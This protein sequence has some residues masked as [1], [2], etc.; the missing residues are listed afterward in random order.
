MAVHRTAAGVL[1][2]VPR[3]GE[4]AGVTGPGG[5]GLVAGERRRRAL[6]RKVP[7]PAR[8]ARGR[9]W[10]G[11][12]RRPTGRAR[13]AAGPAGRAPPRRC[14]AGFGVAWAA[15]DRAAGR[16]PIRAS[17]GGPAPPCGICAMTRGARSRV[18]LPAGRG[19]PRLV[20]RSSWPWSAPPGPGQPRTATG[21]ASRAGGR[22]L[23]GEGLVAYSIPYGLQAAADPVMGVGRWPRVLP[24]NVAEV[25]SRHL[26]GQDPAGG[27][28]SPSSWWPGTVFGGLRPAAVRRDH[29]RHRDRGV[30][31]ARAAPDQQQA[32]P[33][34]GR[35]ARRAQAGIERTAARRAEAS[36]MDEMQTDGH[37]RP[38]AARGRRSRDAAGLPGLPAGHAGVEMPGPERRAAA[39]VAAADVD[40]AGRDAQAPGLCRGLLVHRGGRRGAVPGT[41]GQRGLDADPD[42]DWH[43]AAADSGGELRA[44]WADR[45]ERSAAVLDA[46]PARVRPRPSARRTRRGAGGAACHCDGSWCTWSRILP[47][48]TVTPT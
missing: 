16:P 13:P 1:G 47:A 23:V 7:G 20:P 3:P 15:S 34:T 10:T 14:L 32:R 44:L 12:D 43:S 17:C 42:W 46:R 33:P 36:V 40:D 28:P 26:A 4:R 24:A 35:R 6:G 31:A 41:V 29:P 2:R 37:G 48:T 38:A 30:P 45:A 11:P 9:T 19:L 25:M 27:R 18:R 5:P 22:H 39:G 8:P 21:L